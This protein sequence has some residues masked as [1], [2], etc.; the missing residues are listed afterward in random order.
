M[1]L[2]IVA[3]LALLAGACS[4]DGDGDTTTTA[5]AAGETTT[6]AEAT[7][8]AP[9]KAPITVAAINQQDGV[10]AWPEVTSAAN[11]II[12]WYNAQGG[13]DGHPIELNLCTAGDEPESTQ[14]CAQQFANDDNVEY[15]FPMAVP[16]SDAMFQVIGASGKP[17]V[18]HL[19]WDIP[20]SIQTDLYSADPGVLPGATVIMEHLVLDLGLQSIAI[21]TTDSPFGRDTADLI[22]FLLGEYGATTQ[23][24]FY[25][26][27]TADY[28]PAFASVDLESV[29]AVLF[30]PFTLAECVP[31]AEALNTLGWDKTTISTDFCA[32][33][34]FVES[35]LFEGWLFAN[36]TTALIDGDPD[37]ELLI[38]IF[39]EYGDGVKVDGFA[40]NGALMTFWLI[41]VLEDAYALAGSEVITGDNIR[42]AAEAWS[43]HLTIGPDTL[44]C[45][46]VDP[47][48]AV[49]NPNYLI[50]LLQDGKFVEEVPFQVVD[51]S[52]YAPLLEG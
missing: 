26:E 12:D 25:D 49:C 40:V 39:E 15:V 24:V 2:A 4:D 43:G 51:L 3:S 34:T 44:D 18:G 13:I 36:P 6:T 33:E 41:E 35:G 50:M 5:A 10:V 8:T 29:D 17:M 11:A 27:G 42:A 21:V 7:T 9:P 22:G 23:A 45:P 46:G 38:S 14:A 28:L 20:D 37:R 48:V 16:S 52:V 1:W 19:L 31:A 32:A 30:L 47:F